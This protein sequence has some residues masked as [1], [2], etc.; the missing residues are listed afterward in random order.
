PQGVREIF[1]APPDAFRPAAQSSFGPVVGE[2]SLFLL[3]GERHARERQVRLQAELDSGA[4]PER[5]SYLEC[6][7][8]EALR[9]NPVVN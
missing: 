3:H 1:G 2:H 8:R 9:L 7:C 5:L 4:D 6:V